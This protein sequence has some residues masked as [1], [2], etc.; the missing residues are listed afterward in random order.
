MIVSFS[1]LGSPRPSISPN[2]HS[3]NNN[4]QLPNAFP[5]A[6][7]AFFNGLDA[8]SSKQLALLNATAQARAAHAQA[9]VT[10]GQTS[11]NFIGGTDGG[12]RPDNTFPSR[13]H[14]LPAAA[15]LAS[16]YNMQQSGTPG[17]AP[18]MAQQSPT[19]AMGAS[20]RQQLTPQQQQQM[21]MIQKQR[22]IAFLQNLSRTYA[23]QHIPLPSSISGIEAPPDPNAVFPSPWRD[24]EPASEP[25]GVKFAGRDVDLFRLWSMV[26]SAGGASKMNQQGTWVNL[27][28][29]LGLPESLPQP[30]ENGNTSTATALA[31]LYMKLFSA[32]DENHYKQMS[33]RN[34]LAQQGRAQP[35]QP[36]GHNASIPASIPGQSHQASQSQIQQQQQQS[37][38]Q[39]QSAPAVSVDQ[40]RTPAPGS[41]NEDAEARKRKTETGEDMHMKR[42]RT[43]ALRFIPSSE[44]QRRKKE[45]A[46]FKFIVQTPL[47]LSIR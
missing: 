24:L 13:A 15:A 26:L 36:G 34:A 40:P 42:R 8:S 45:D 27:P 41:A 39:P 30:Q 4:N 47:L 20:A 2:T 1:P 19:P 31:Q 22:R 5:P 12:P 32:F 3:D 11:A 46:N 43:S 14:Q 44:R 17:S 38:P 28:Q 9:A 23:S 6:G 16:S 37:Q 29:F 33:E 10:A 21:A 18:G 7:N 25:G 35:A